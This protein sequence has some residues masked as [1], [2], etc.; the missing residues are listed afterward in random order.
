[1]LAV[2]DVRREQYGEQGVKALLVGMLRAAKRLLGT[3]PTVVTSETGTEVRVPVLALDPRIEDGR[4]IPRTPGDSEAV[5]LNWNPYFSPTWTDISTATQAAL[6]ANGGK[7]VISQRTAVQAIQSLW[8]VEDVDA[9]MELIE[10]DADAAVK[11]MQ[12]SMAASGP[13][14]FGEES[15]TPEAPRPETEAPPEP[16][17]E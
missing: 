7:Q 3:A 17:Q 16:E 1:M 13:A 12:E 8:G 4:P 11:R 6:A 5:V 2:A 14:P 10:E 9:E 15:E